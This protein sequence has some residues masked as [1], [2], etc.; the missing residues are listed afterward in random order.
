MSPKKKYFS[1][2]NNSKNLLIAVL[3]LLLG[4]SLFTQ[5]AQSAPKT[6]DALKLAQY[7]ACVN[8]QPNLDIAL[9]QVN[10]GN[11]DMNTNDAINVNCVRYRP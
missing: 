8:A 11:G 3:T 7:T 2:M 5:P 6:Y 4:V 10:G 9:I 1:S